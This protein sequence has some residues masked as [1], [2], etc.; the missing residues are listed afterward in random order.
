M[1]DFS[2]FNFFFCNPFPNGNPSFDINNPLTP[3]H[4]WYNLDHG[5]LFGQN[6][7]TL[8]A[9]GVIGA[10]IPGFPGAMSGDRTAPTSDDLENFAKLFKQKRIKLG[11][12]Q[13]DVGLALGQLYGN[14]F[15]GVRGIY[16]LGNFFFHKG[17]KN[18]LTSNTITSSTWEVRL[19]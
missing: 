2:S 14:V 1:N 17:L 12:T 3:F 10:G 9:G 8:G 11:F 6:P 5:N 13:A 16:F 7:A 15:S 19:T 18:F 4:N